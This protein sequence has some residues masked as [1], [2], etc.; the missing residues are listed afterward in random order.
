MTNE[1]K[2][3]VVVRWPL[4]GIRTYMRYMFRYFPK[5]YS[6]T[7]LAVSTQENDALIHDA[8]G[9]GAR[10]VLASRQG[11]LGLAR[12]V[13]AELRS[14]EYDVIM[15]QGFIS[16]IAAYC[17]N[18]LARV[19]HILTIHGVV[20][21][22]YV[23]GRFARAKSF[24]MEQVLAGIT[25]HYAVSNDILAHLHEQFPRLKGGLPREVVIPN[26]IDMQE[27]E[28]PQKRPSTIRDRLGIPAS[29]FLFGFFGR[30]MHQKGFDLLIEAVT[31]M[32]QEGT[33]MPFAILAVGSGDYL[34]S[35]QH[36]VKSKKLDQYF[37]FLPFQSQVRDLYLEVNTIVMPSRWEAC[38]LQPM[39]AL[40][41]GVPLIAADCIGLRET[42][43]GTPANV[44]PAGDVD[45]LVKVMRDTLAEPRTAEFLTYSSQARQRYDVALSARHLVRLIAELS[46][47]QQ[48]NAGCS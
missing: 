23:T 36:E 11:V 13:V 37:I 16:A 31:R 8:A 5:H 7:L 24:L 29:T 25:V 10:L 40:S 30:F 45:G 20:E 26:G 22:K 35:Y 47:Q 39:E 19:P 46:E 48:T 18:L 34:S 15:S 28:V 32:Q 33:A 44:F 41:M 43:A 17:A 42:V 4:G 38:P 12:E 2:I 21:E 27:F 6:L 9:Y 14:C 1:K 3:L